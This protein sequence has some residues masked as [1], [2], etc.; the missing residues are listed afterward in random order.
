MAF[1]I[2]LAKHLLNMAL[3]FVCLIALGAGFGWL[4]DRIEFFGAYVMLTLFAIS[5]VVCAWQD[6]KVKDKR[7]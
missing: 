1:L 3:F 7:K 2:Y 6:Y 5:V 4:S